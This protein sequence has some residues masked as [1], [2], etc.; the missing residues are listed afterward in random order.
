MDAEFETIGATDVFTRFVFLW[1]RDLLGRRM[2]VSSPAS[3]IRV[4]T[5]SIGICCASPGGREGAECAFSRAV[6]RHDG[7][8]APRV[9]FAGQGHGRRGEG[10]PGESASA[11]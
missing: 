11:V 5:R 4:G 3:G 10:R 1:T 7:R 9:H 8:T 2:A 6:G